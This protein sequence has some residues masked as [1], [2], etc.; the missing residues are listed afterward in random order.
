M[1]DDSEVKG[2]VGITDERLPV[3]K[4]VADRAYTI[5]AFR[6]RGR[7]FGE[8]PPCGWY[9]ELACWFREMIDNG[10]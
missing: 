10:S 3:I 9:C 1:S 2:E 8:R 7:S 6:L 4:L 5:L